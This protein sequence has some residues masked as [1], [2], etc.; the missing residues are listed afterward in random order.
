MRAIEKPVAGFC[1]RAGMRFSYVLEPWIERPQYSC[2]LPN[3]VK[4]MSA[5]YKETFE[6]KLRRRLSYPAQANRTGNVG[7][8]G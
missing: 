8:K 6:K 3:C 4:D 7:P 2:N 1:I 5:Y